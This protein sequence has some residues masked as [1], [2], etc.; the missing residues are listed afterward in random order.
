MK[1][2]DTVERAPGLTGHLG[3]KRASSRPHRRTSAP[4]GMFPVRPGAFERS[5]RRK[6]TGPCHS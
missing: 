3:G 6:D 2:P 5:Q 1:R 4:A